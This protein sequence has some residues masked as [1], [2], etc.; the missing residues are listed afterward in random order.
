[1]TSEYVLTKKAVLS[2]CH[3]LWE[4]MWPKT[5][6]PL[7]L[8]L[9]LAAILLIIGRFIGERKTPD[10]F[11]TVSIDRIF[12]WESPIILPLIE[13]LP[14][15]FSSSPVFR[16]AT[17]LVYVAGCAGVFFFPRRRAAYVLSL[18]G[19]SSMVFLDHSLAGAHLA[20]VYLPLFLLLS[21][22]PPEIG[23]E[24]HVQKDLITALALMYFFSAVNKLTDFYLS[25]GVLVSTYSELMRST[26]QGALQYPLLVQLATILGLLIQFASALIVFSRFRQF[27]LLAAVGFHI[28]FGG[29]IIK[30]V[31][32]SMFALLLPLLFEPVSS[33]A[34]DR[35]LLVL[36]S[37]GFF[38]L[39]LGWRA[40]PYSTKT[41]SMVWIVD[42][43][44]WTSLGVVSW[45]AVNSLRKKGVF[46]GSAI[47]IPGM[48][49][50]V[51]YF[52]AAKAFS[53]PE[54]LGYSQYS[55]RQ[56]E[57]FGAV[58]RG[59]SVSDANSLRGMPSRWGIRF[60]K[61]SDG[62]VLGLFP[63]P[64]VLE[65]AVEGFCGRFPGGMVMRLKTPPLGASLRVDKKADD[66]LAE[67]QLLPPEVSCSGYQHPKPN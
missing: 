19:M 8:F 18:V 47:S 17:T 36:Q 54:P 12:S 57:Y 16:L 5:D 10:G 63:T 7:I 44:S 62:A 37:L 24:E 51:V 42:F 4:K 9:R 11:Y 23:N 34:G 45:T 56:Q 39:L 66:A 29:T 43:A 20:V 64:A 6:S 50:P 60:S 26:I 25:G 55:G 14:Y 48:L 61:L 30:S 13:L 2:Q 1:M 32:M 53:W 15:S 38:G 41:D 27:G 3:G 52:V 58:F 33:A 49:M 28:I 22:R 31:N 21:I 35:R 40:L 65:H 67:Y 59:N 46:S